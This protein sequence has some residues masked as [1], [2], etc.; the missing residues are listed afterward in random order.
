MEHCQA[1]WDNRLQVGR[2]SGQGQPVR[3][4]WPWTA[5]L[6]VL[7]VLGFAAFVR[8]AR[9]QVMDEDFA[10]AVKEWTTRPEF[11]SPLVD[12]LPLSS[13]VPSPK[14]F[15]GEHIGAANILHY[16]HDIY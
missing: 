10:R 12:H 13:T 7:I 1:H 14:S 9:T 6:A 3:L 4:A 8:P 11:L 16:T 2:L 15:L 5:A